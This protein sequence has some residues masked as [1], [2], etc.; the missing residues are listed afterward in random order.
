MEQAKI[1]WSNVPMTGQSRV[2]ERKSTGGRSTSKQSS[3]GRYHYKL[4]T[5][6]KVRGL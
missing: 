3:T 4:Q 1:N 2:G 5:S 6:L